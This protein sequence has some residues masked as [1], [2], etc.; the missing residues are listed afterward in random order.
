MGRSGRLML[1]VVPVARR[2]PIGGNRIFRTVR[3]AVA[4]AIAL[5]VVSGATVAQAS[6]FGVPSGT[7]HV[8]VG[9]DVYHTSSATRALC[10]VRTIPLSTITERPDG[11]HEYHY[12]INGSP[13]ILAIPPAG[14]N[15]LTAGSSEREA[16]GLPQ[17]PPVTET[18]ARARWEEEMHNFHVQA[19]PAS[20][21]VPERPHETTSSSALA[22][23]LSAQ[24]STPPGDDEAASP[25]ASQEGCASC[26]AGY[27]DTGAT[28]EKASIFYKEPQRLDDCAG[29]EASFWVGLGGYG[30]QPLDQA[31]TELGKGF[32]IAE[33]QAWIE[34]YEVPVEKS[35]E[36]MPYPFFATPGAYFQVIV[37][38]SSGRKYTVVFYNSAT[39][40]FSAP[41]VHES[42]EAY[43]GNSAEFIAERGENTP[44]ADFSR[45]EVLE[46]W[47]W[48]QGETSGNTVS[49]F[50]HHAEEH[51][52][53]GSRRVAS[54]SGLETE[55]GSLFH[56]NWEGYSDSNTC[57]PEE[58][59]LDPSS[60]TWAV[61]NA[62]GNNMNTFYENTGDQLAD[63]NWINGGPGNGWSSQTLASGAG[64]V[65][66]P[67]A[68]EN[69]A[70]NNTNVFYEN[71]S[72]ELVDEYW[73]AGGPG[74]GWSSLVLASG[75]AGP[76][77]AVV[78][79]AG[80]N[81]NVFYENTSGQLVDEF[82]ING[83]PG[84][85]WS[86]QVL[87]SGMAGPLT[88]VEN[89]AGTNMNVF[90][91][92]TSGQ[93]VDEFWV[94]GSPGN[95]WSSQVL[96]SGV[97]MVGTPT[98]IEN[99]A[100][101]NM[102][103]F[104][105]NTS[106]QLVDEFWINGGPNNGWSS[107]VLA[108]GMAGSPTA[109]MNT[110]ETN[111]NVF[112]ENTSGQLVDEYWIN[113]GP[114]NGWSSQVLAS[115]VGMV[116]TPASIENNAGTNMNV[117]YENTS[118]ELVDEFWINSGPNNGW[119][120]QVLAPGMAGPPTAETKAATSVGGASA[121]LHGTVKPDGPETKYYFEY[122]TS[123]SYGSK[124]AEES[125]GS[126]SG[127]VEV[128]K[129]IAGLAVGTR[130]DFR[131]VAANSRGTEKGANEA[132]TTAAVPVNTALPTISGPGNWG[133]APISGSPTFTAVSCSPGTTG[134]SGL[135]LAMTGASDQAYAATDPAGGSGDW[136]KSTINGSGA[137]SG[138]SCAST[139]F[140]VATVG[141]QTNI[142]S[143]SGTS[144]TWTDNGANASHFAG[145]S[146]TSA[147][148][149]A[150]IDSSYGVVYTTKPT[151]V[152]AWT[153][154]SGDTLTEEKGTALSCAPGTTSTSGLCV[155]VGTGGGISAAT[156][157]AG[158]WTTST[159]DGTNTITAVSCAST[160]F[161]AAVDNAGYLLTSTKPSEASSWVKTDIDGS[162]TLNGVS[163]PTTSFC[164]AVDNQG[165]VL[166]S[167][168]PTGGAGA[169]KAES[170]D[171]LASLVGISCTS[172]TFCATVDNAG[173]II[174]YTGSAANWLT[175]TAGA[176]SNEPSSY[177]YQWER[178]NS[179][180]SE[181]STIS[182]QTGTSYQEGSADV[183]HSLRVEVTATNAVGSGKAT[184]AASA[185]VSGV[186]SFAI[187]SGHSMEAISCSPG[188][189]GSSGLCL[190]LATEHRAYVATDPEGGTGDWVKTP[191]TSGESGGVYGASCASTSFC[192]ATVW[193][194]TNIG[195]VSGTSVTWTD[196]GANASHFAGVSCTSTTFCAH[197]DS[198]SGVVYTT[199]PTAVEAW[200]GASG[201]TLT[202]EK[203]TALSCAPGTT[204][205]SGLCVDV[206]T[207]GG[208]SAATDP[209]GTWTTSTV[210]GTNTITAVSCA[211]TSFCAAVDNA[212]YLLTSTK[213]SEA[214]SWVKTD[215]DGSHTLNGVSCPTTSFCAAVDNQ[216][217][218]LISTN[219]T[220]GAGAWKAESI[221]P[222]ASLVGISCTSN[223]FCATV[224]T[225]GNVM[226]F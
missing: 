106:G 42:R 188:T 17:E 186:R 93:L 90:Y 5:L 47:A 183:G 124:T 104:Y 142:G 116:G 96:A 197:I 226:T 156:D 143:V 100:G 76:P 208:I 9:L 127:S 7:P 118:H 69:I 184:S 52:Y 136:V 206:G 198:S 157:P 180:G 25:K 117:F 86:S 27:V 138:A 225:S 68:I 57:T 83:S 169:W 185:V 107:Q 196:N 36:P 26:W 221:D 105:E 95:G 199:K 13:I 73:E 160:S 146:C 218:V 15:P 32:L 28:F 22:P 201:D 164:A 153:G 130:Y 101:T 144:V 49:G 21:Y 108:S 165:Q 80:T 46:A 40:E 211:S 29:D 119:S 18:A 140:C 3:M 178:C 151:A 155:D 141:G 11:G 84:N 126:G 109:V 24:G 139:S 203:G 137:T 123:T 205:T 112:Y 166:I 37:T 215:I 216:G 149:C 223:T 120:S 12:E 41:A 103:V 8:C 128:S 10:H 48:A 148:F 113:G 168:N 65:G 194:Q 219:P 147:T 79:V 38:H 163:C 51:I 152:E 176:W 87:A 59:P 114:G 129:A 19:P 81:M 99:S 44:L 20:L 82:W 159:V 64:M 162:H 63:E 98:A 172:S 125:A 62:A 1:A 191:E 174:T 14:F 60:S 30:S 187:D 212:G 6:P 53:A 154:A 78:N 16:Y 23:E 2:G 158:T 181:C 170:I 74:N 85:G 200:T 71:T 195:S 45:W 39:K 97:G 94:N 122:G 50:Q 33:N 222:L 111:M 192:V 88:A 204:S 35:D 91:E 173:H 75:M 171:P 207:G 55:R 193:G 58:P 56:V 145:V 54:T 133:S 66:P 189:T 190:A 131:I 135:C 110:A 213:P 182:G 89:T 214:S 224:D 220:G 115:G 177:A 202:E 179:G 102:N 72:H 31:G 210:D 175:A 167:T 67:A 209:A 43:N 77:T 134:S 70:G 161:C 132:F 34:N 61:E 217:Q 4:A 150:H 92:N 121:T